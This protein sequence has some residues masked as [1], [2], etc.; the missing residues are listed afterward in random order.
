M[1]SH[2]EVKQWAM[3]LLA[4]LEKIGARFRYMDDDEPSRIVV[5]QNIDRYVDR[6][7]VPPGN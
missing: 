3:K 4:E 5:L 7:I 1:L 6:W 2:E